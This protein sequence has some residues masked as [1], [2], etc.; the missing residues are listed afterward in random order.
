MSRTSFPVT[1]LDPCNRDDVGPAVIFEPPK[2]DTVTNQNR[3]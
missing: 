3:K 1:T 2:D